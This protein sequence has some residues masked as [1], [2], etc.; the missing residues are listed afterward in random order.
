VGA[1]AV[2]ATD[3]VVTVPPE[4]TVPPTSD[5]PT[6]ATTLVADPVTHRVVTVVEGPLGCV[7]QPPSITV[8]VGST[9]TFQNNSDGDL[10]LVV[11]ETTISL[12]SGFS[13]SP[14][15]LTTEGVVTVTCTLGGD[16]AP[17]GMTVTVTG[18]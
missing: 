7:F 15:P 14:Y 12:E 17:A 16:T 13:S 9:V 8:V 4:P 18:G 10:T 2:P 1:T 5:P 6:T 11:G 3:P